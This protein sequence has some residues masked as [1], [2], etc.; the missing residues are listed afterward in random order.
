MRA[1][2]STPRGVCL[3]SLRIQTALKTTFA[4]PLWLEISS[5]PESEFLT[6]P[7]PNFHRHRHSNFK[8]LMIFVQRRVVE[9]VC[10]E[11]PAEVLKLAELGAKFTRTKK[12]SLHLTR[13]GGHSARRV[14]HAADATGKLFAYIAASF[15]T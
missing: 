11:G 2:H 3:L 6:T 4:T 12:G 1:A 5:T 8:V 10:R 7:A 14:V 9:A 13:E 15:Y